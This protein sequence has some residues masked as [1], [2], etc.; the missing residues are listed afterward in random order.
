MADP[1]ME[2]VYHAEP[3]PHVLALYYQNDWVGVF[4]TVFQGNTTQ[5]ALDDFLGF[6]LTNLLEQGH[7][8][9]PK[10]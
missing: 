1:D 9:A 2:I 10:E 5:V 7:Q 8:L 4:Q 3:Q 6:W